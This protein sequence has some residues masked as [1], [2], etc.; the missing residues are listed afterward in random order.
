MPPRIAGIDYG[1]K[2]V[3][4]A[5]SDPLRLFAQPYGTFRPA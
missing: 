2:R 3:G 1:T 4:V 5:L